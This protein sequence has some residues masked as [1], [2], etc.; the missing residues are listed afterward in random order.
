MST[1]TAISKH[2]LVGLYLTTAI[3]MVSYGAIFSLLAEI[4][5]TFGFSATG[6][7]FIGAAAFIS[8][9][10]AQL[11]L[12]RYADLGYGNLMMKA[13][14]LSCIIATVWCRL[15]SQCIKYNFIFGSLGLGLICKFMISES[16]KPSTL[17]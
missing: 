15:L 8:G 4:R 1:S 3:L 14:L 16:P 12:S 13:G 11:G 5:D 10:I 17:I 9:F 6:V 7:G 2:K